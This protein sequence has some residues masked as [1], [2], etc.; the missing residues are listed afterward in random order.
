MDQTCERLHDIA[1]LRLDTEGF[2]KLPEK[3]QLLCMH[4]AQAGLWGRMIAMDQGSAANLPLARSLAELRQSAPA[5]HPSLPA[6]ENAL[7]TFFAHN[8]IY[9]STSGELLALPIGISELEACKSFCPQAA[10]QAIDILFGSPLP[11]FRTVQT[12]GADGVAQS[13]GNFYS[14]LTQAEALAFRKQNAPAADPSGQNPPHGFNQRLAKLPDGSVEAQTVKIGGLY[15]PY[16]EKIAQCLE[17]A[18]PYAEND[19]QRESIAS[20]IRFYHTGDPADFDR[21]CIAWTQ[22]TESNV[23]F[24]NGLIESYDDPLSIACSF[25]SIVAFKNPLQTAKVQKIIDHIQWFEDRLPIDPEFK[26]EKAQGLSASSI[27]VVSMAGDAAPSLPL[28]VNLPNSEWIR[29]AH[30]SKSVN[31]ANVAGSRGG[32]EAPLRQELYLP[33]YQD[34]LEKYASLSNSL[35]TDLHEIAGH[36]SGKIRPGANP[37]DLGPFY[38]TIEEARA[39]LVGLYHIADPKLK[40]IGVFGPGEDQSQAVL[41][42]YVS[43]L[44]NGAFGQLRRV[45][46]GNDLTQAHFRNRQLIATW[47]LRHADPD[48]ARMVSKDGKAYIEVNDPAHLRELFGKLLR[49]VQSIKSTADFEGAKELVME[50]G[51]RVD[52]ELHRQTLSRIEK[53][54]MPKVVGFATPVIEPCG[55]GASIRQCASFLEQQIE[56]HRAFEAPCAP[57]PKPKSPKR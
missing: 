8:G 21:H 44:T 38:S 46:Q 30:G 45:A 39:D 51:T 25:E 14:G 37:D 42:Q 9:H 28:G 43:Y 31:L 56:L 17:N 52:P 32:F 55:A 36:G 3:Q 7:F 57:T 40:E 33:K 50:Y 53:L 48:K 19:K 22:D 29:A 16:A 27:T 13:G 34:C 4:L 35:H 23:F 10:A 6:I 2:E 1:I 26:K 11:R 15:G 12:D 24:I 5:G 54:D 18:L 47:A 49:I 20:L 41:A